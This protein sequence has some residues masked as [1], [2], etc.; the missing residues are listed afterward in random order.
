[1]KSRP[2]Q[3]GT[4]VNAGMF[5]F[6]WSVSLLLVCFSSVGLFLFCWSVSLLFAKAADAFLPV[7]NPLPPLVHA[8][9]IFA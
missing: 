3:C 6:C 9:L 4:E 1:M 2:I 5:L 8:G 7:F